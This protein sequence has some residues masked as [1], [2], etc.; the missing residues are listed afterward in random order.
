LLLFVIVQIQ[1]APEDIPQ[2]IQ[3]DR[4]NLRAPVA[5]LLRGPLVWRRV[6][7]IFGK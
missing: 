6:A 4:I 2:G 5:T 7:T 3:R 1:G